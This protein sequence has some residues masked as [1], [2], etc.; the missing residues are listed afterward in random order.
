MSWN[1]K[2]EIKVDASFQETNKNGFIMVQTE[3]YGADEEVN[4]IVQK[5]KKF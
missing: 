2:Y 3:M 1:C 4:I 5:N